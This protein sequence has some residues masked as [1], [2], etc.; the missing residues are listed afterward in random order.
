MK[1][2]IIKTYND[3]LINMKVNDIN[4]IN[5]GIIDNNCDSILFT[6]IIHCVENINIFNEQQLLNINN[7]LNKIIYGK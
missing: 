1:E 7:Y 4:K 6:I 2:D 3:L 5:Y